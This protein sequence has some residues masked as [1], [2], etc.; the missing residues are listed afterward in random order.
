M[1]PYFFRKLVRELPYLP[2][3]L[4]MSVASS[5]EL[6]PPVPL[7]HPATL[8]LHT[9]LTHPPSRH[10]LALSVRDPGANQNMPA[11]TNAFIQTLTIRGV[12]KVSNEE[13]CQWVRILRPD[14]L[15]ALPDVPKTQGGANE[16]EA[17]GKVSVLPGEGRAVSQKRTGKSLDRT[18]AWLE[19]LLAETV[20][21]FN[22]GESKEQRPP[23]FVQLMGGR[24]AR[25]RKEFSKMLLEKLNKPD[26]EKV[27]GLRTLDEGVAG[28]VVELVDLPTKA[29]RSPPPP[30]LNET[31]NQIE[32]DF[33]EAE[34]DDLGWNPVH[35]PVTSSTVTSLIRTSLEVLP[36]SKPRIAHTAPSPHS[37][38]RLVLE[39]GIDLF[40]TVWATE[41]ADL[42]VALEFEFPAPAHPSGATPT[43]GLL[44]IGR[45]LFDE[46]YATDFSVLGAGL[47][48]H[49][50]CASCHPRFSDIPLVHSKTDE[51]GTETRDNS[52]HGYTRAYIHHLV[53]THEM[54][55]YTLLHFH[56]LAVVEEFFVSI[57]TVLKRSCDEFEKEVRRFYDVYDPG[58]GVLEEA[59]V[60]WR[61]V[62]DARGKG[63]L[64]REREIAAK[65][66]TLQE[67]V[68]GWAADVE[69][70]VAVVE[71]V[72]CDAEVTQDSASSTDDPCKQLS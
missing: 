1:A 52:A 29:F 46:Q 66:A 11:N 16:D 7:F 37:I 67:G 32:E 50:G 65:A 9:F 22:D 53:H 40:D 35:I 27:G 13:W 58:M 26:S 30:N 34:G 21:T 55:S 17:V 18:T 3:V 14:V 61:E 12:K 49:C 15:Y 64:K 41:A 68:A 54:S 69:S 25:A 10:I 70:S 39:C 19:G 6:S 42:G 33:E 24:R 28:Y 63:R 44:P 56:N 2:L 72:G 60:R 59:R 38:L 47:H 5:L 71:T 23:V 36:Q 62:E 4:L 48:N 45:N 57:R 51:P 31:E 20:P 8:P 43:N